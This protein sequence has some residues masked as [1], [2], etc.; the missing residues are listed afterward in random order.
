MYRLHK[1]VL[2]I[3]AIIQI[4][5]RGEDF[6]QFYKIFFIEV[7]P[8]F[9]SDRIVVYKGT[10]YETIRDTVSVRKIVGLNTYNWFMLQT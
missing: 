1:K 9:L 3:R 8:Y 5:V 7:R 10:V 4:I 6:D 2:T